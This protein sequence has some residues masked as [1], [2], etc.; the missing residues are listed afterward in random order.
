MVKLY[1]KIPNKQFFFNLLFYSRYLNFRVLFNILKTINLQ[2]ALSSFFATQ[3]FAFLTVF[4]SVKTNSTC[5]LCN[6]PIIAIRLITIYYSLIKRK[7][8]LWLFQKNI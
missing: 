1:K 3:L 7:I 5:F 2:V 8:Q 6:K 4:L